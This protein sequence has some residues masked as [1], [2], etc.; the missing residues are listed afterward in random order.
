MRSSIRCFLSLFLYSRLRRRSSKRASPLSSDSREDRWCLLVS[1]LDKVV[2]GALNPPRVV[3]LPVLVRST[4]RSDF[5][6]VFCC[7]S[8]CFSKGVVFS[9]SFLFWTKFK[10]KSVVVFK[11]IFLRDDDDEGEKEDFD[12]DERALVTSTNSSSIVVA[13]LSR[14]G[15]WLWY[16]VVDDDVLFLVENQ[17]GW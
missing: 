2:G 6:F 3:S 17:R 14:D 12:A 7:C 16:T 13:F 5:F 8:C 15:W 11:D 1:S 10:A 9:S 4:L